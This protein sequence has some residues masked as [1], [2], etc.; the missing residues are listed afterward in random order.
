MEQIS[1][2][3]NAQ[4]SREPSI[5]PT[6]KL[7][8]FVFVVLCVYIYIHVYMYKYILHTHIVDIIMSHYCP[9]FPS[10]SWC[11]MLWPMTEK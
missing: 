2:G 4:D 8:V 3:T 10:V 5:A 9:K 1:L 6:L 11:I 7:Y